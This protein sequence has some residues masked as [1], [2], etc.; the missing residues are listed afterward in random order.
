M[1][2]RD[3]QYNDRRAAVIS[4]Y[5]A[6]YQSCRAEGY[7][8]SECSDSVYEECQDDPFWKTNPPFSFGFADPQ[9]DASGLCLTPS[10]G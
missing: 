3:H 10:H 4:V 6:D 7:S 1:K 2:Y 5:A 9:S 8:H